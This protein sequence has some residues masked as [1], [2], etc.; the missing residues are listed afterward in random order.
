MALQ[1]NAPEAEAHAANEAVQAARRAVILARTA[2][3]IED[4]GVGDQIGDV[5]KVT[6]VEYNSLTKNPNTLYVITD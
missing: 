2:Q 1:T 5:I 4:D 6:Q 3:L